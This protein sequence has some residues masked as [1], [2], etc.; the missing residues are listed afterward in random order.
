MN[1]IGRG[2]DRV[3]GPVEFEC[4]QV[5][6][7]LAPDGL[8][9]ARSADDRDG[10]RSK[11]TVQRGRWPVTSASLRHEGERY[12]VCS[13]R[14]GDV[15]FHKAIVRHLSANFA[16]GLTSSGL[17]P[18]D[19]ARAREQH[20]GY[21]SALAACGVAVTCLPEDARFPDATFVEDT[22][23]LTTEGSILCRPGAASR[24]GEV[25]AIRDAVDAICP[26]VDEIAAPGTVDGG[27]VCQAGGTFFI[28]ISA[29]TDPDGAGQLA[30]VLKKL[31]FDAVLV[32]IR[33]D[34][35]LLHLK[36]GLA[37]LGGRRLAAVGALAAHRAF[38]AYDVLPVPAGEDYAANCVLVNGRLILAS[39]F[40]RFEEALR[41]AGQEMLTLPM[42]EFQKMDGGLSCL[43]LRF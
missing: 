27:D 18:P 20:E 24:A 43:S 3:D 15:T 30:A 35:G 28:G 7:N 26:V 17:G 32:D 22:A 39:G 36:S 11:N 2:V 41:K 34:A 29:R 10:S 13:V 14:E 25:D 12:Q 40:P 42:S 21:V 33:G 19:L 6:Q 31:G 5:G 9:L 37:W 38:A 1:R 8:P 23:V 4:D 16:D